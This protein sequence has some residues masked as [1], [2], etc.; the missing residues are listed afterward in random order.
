MKDL[1]QAV[2]F[3]LL[4]D[5]KWWIDIERH[6]I[7]MPQSN[8]YDQMEASYNINSHKE[9]IRQYLLQKPVREMLDKSE[10]TKFTPNIEQWQNWQPVFVD[11]DNNPLWIDAFED[12]EVVLC[13]S[14]DQLIDRILCN[15]DYFWNPEHPEVRKLIYPDWN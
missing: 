11:S 9:K 10:V 13:W 4:E 7:G 15:Y 14:L 2:P 5:Q 8:S 3:I 1:R 12:M 6:I